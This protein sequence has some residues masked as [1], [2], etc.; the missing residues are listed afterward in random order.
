HAGARNVVERI[1]GVFK[2]RFAAIRNGTEYPMSTQACI[3]PACAVLHNFI[4]THDPD[5]W[6]DVETDEEEELE[7]APERGGALGRG[8]AVR[9]IETRRAGKRRDEIAQAMWAD[10][11]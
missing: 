10:Y 3:F 7:D 4:R 1:F 6:S 11:Q 9:P 8:G 2:K 5:D